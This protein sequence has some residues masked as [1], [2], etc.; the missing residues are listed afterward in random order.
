MK[1]RLEG[2]GAARLIQLMRQHGYNKDV[3]IELATVT[4]APPNIKVKIDNMNIELDHDDLIVAQSLM[5]HK[6]QVKINGGT[7]S[8]FENQD[9]LEVGDRIIVAAVKNDQLFIVLG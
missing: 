1:E 6:R 3:D 5:K 7:T 9:E 2:N 4:S 8:E